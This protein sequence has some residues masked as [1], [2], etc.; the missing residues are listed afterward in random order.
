MTTI[1]IPTDFNEKSVQRSQDILENFK[2][3]KVKLIFFHAYTLT[4]SITDLLM[5]TRRTAEYGQIPEAFHKACHELRQQN[6]ATIAGVGIEYY[7]GNTIASFR[8]F[9]EAQE[10]DAIFYPADYQFR[11]ISKYSLDPAVL[12]GRSGLPV[13]SPVKKTP[14][15]IEKIIIPEIHEPVTEMA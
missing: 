7:Y 1:L 13:I 4:D 11:K 8:N 3:E 2:D 9:A 6:K 12:I 14:V 15:V 5:L 10:V